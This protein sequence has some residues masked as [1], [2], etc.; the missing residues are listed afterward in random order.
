[1]AERQDAARQRARRALPSG[2]PRLLGLD[3]GT[4]TIGL[5]L[6]D[7]ERRIASPLETHQARRSS[8][9]TPSTSRRSSPRFGIGGARLRPAAQHGRHAKARA[10]SRPAPSRA[11]SPPHAA[12]PIAV[13]GRA[14]VDRR[15]EPDA[16]RCDASRAAAPSSSTRWP[17]PTSS[18]VSWRRSASL[19]IPRHTHKIPV[20]QFLSCIRLWLETVGWGGLHSLR[21]LVRMREFMKRPPTDAA[22]HGDRFAPRDGGTSS[23]TGPR[24][25]A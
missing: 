8:P 18:R 20:L 11:I 21:C 4:K 3:L 14:P 23:V 13:L 24:E 15:R 25:R 6:S 16:H 22:D 10:R 1:M 5:A 7:V 17:P 9:P 2:M 19:A 12:C